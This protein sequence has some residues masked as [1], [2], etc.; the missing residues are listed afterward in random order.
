MLVTFLRRLAGA[1]MLDAATYEEVEAD[2]SAT[3]QALG[4]VLLSSI[5]AGIGLNG[6]RGVA[7]T[8][9]F[10]ALASVLALATW[11]TFAVVTFHVG[12]RLLPV[13]GTRADAGE[14][15]RT[16][17]FAAAP[18]VI[19]VFGLF[20][21]APIATAVL[22]LAWTIA[23]SVVAVRQALDFNSTGRAIAVCLVGWGLPLAIAA[24]LAVAV[25]GG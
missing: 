6:A 21:P 4:V 18:G 23:A 16:L 15:L 17:G 11:A 19:Q 2:R 20:S 12:S 25:S 7:A 8:L 1:A 22:A 24:T 10:A 5:A 9:S 13:D 14:L 3:K